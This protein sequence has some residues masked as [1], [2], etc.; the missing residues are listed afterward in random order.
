MNST[1]ATVACVL[2]ICG[3]FLLERD[4]KARTSKALWI[5]TAW[6]LIAASRMVSGWL[7]TAPQVRTSAQY[8][9]G[10]PLDRFILSGL[11]VIAIIVLV[12]RMPRVIAIIR[13]NWPILLFF[14]YCAISILWSD[15]PDVA[16]K[17][18]IKAIGDL[19]MVLI[20]VTDRDRLAAIKRLLT[21][22]GFILVPLSIL[23]V[24]YY[25]K[26]GR[27]YS[28]E[29]AAVA[30][31]GVTL[32]KN[33]LGCLC[34]IVGLASLWRLAV[35][36]RDN[37]R[38]I[39][40][41]LAHG[42]TI[43]MVAWLL[44]MADSVTSLVCFLIG[45][46]LIAVVALPGKRRTAQVHLIVGAV[47]SVALFVLVLPDAYAS[48]VQV[49]G[50]NVT[51]TGRTQLWHV[52]LG[53]NTNPWFGTGFASFWLG[54]RLDTLW[55]LFGGW[56]ATEAHN[57]YLG[58]ILELGWVGLSM[59]AVVLVTG[60]RNVVA[61]FHQDPE[62]GSL[63]LVIFVVAVVYNVAEAAFR[64]MFPIWIFLLWAMIAVPPHSSSEYVKNAEAADPNVFQND[65]TYPRRSVQEEDA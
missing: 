29:D 18:W 1:I 6:V 31:T 51:L 48:I 8:I 9:E 20:V 15:Y 25:P 56:H 27:V 37:S 59:L 23:F 63:R 47:A 7:Q 26:I 22:V 54:N 64:M 12:S 36:S 40:R 53:M 50:R 19:A 2:G 3:L 16:L 52:L 65:R 57:G 11:V 24:E 39:S 14:T 5:P 58:V 30:N 44:Y 10:S 61:A 45:S 13:M 35:L 38:K 28:I 62:V 33:Q 32:N 42:A 46:A 49:L 55:S 60:Y 4:R 17:R 21:R 41:L 34:L 43:A